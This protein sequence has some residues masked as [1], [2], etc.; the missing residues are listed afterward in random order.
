MGYVEAFMLKL[1]DIQAARGRI[2]DFARLTPTAYSETLSRE[3]A[4]GA[5]KERGE[6]DRLLLLTEEE[7]QRGVITASTGNHAQGVAYHAG[8]LKFAHR[9]RCRCSRRS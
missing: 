9:L 8:R 7:R 6:P 3:V 2:R 1:A 4:T 5:F